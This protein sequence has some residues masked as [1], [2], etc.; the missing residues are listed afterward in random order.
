MYLIDANK[1]LVTSKLEELKTMVQDENSDLICMDDKDPANILTTTFATL[2][3]LFENPA[4]EALITDKDTQ[5][6]LYAEKYDVAMTFTGFDIHAWIKPL[7]GEKYVRLNS[8]FKTH[9]RQ[10]RVI[11]HD[12]EKRNAKARASLAKTARKPDTNTYRIACGIKRDNTVVDIEKFEGTQKEMRDFVNKL[13]SRNYVR[14]FGKGVT[15]FCI[16]WQYDADLNDLDNWKTL[17]ELTNEG[18]F[19]K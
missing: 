15:V 10:R 18:V 12:E 16:N 19:K 3:S 17:N 14:T 5:F 11:E 13:F 9:N 7:K 8:L 4:L 1:N 6:T 2:R